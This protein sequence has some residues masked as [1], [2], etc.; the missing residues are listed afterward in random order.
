MVTVNKLAPP[1][2]T[3]DNYTLQQLYGLTHSN[4]TK[5][6]IINTNATELTPP[7]GIT[8]YHEISYNGMK[9]SVVNNVPVL[10]PLKGTA[11]FFVKGDTGY[12]PPI[13]CKAN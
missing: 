5:Y 2:T 8:A 11:I 13:P 1:I 10:V 6:T 7:T 9:N 12:S 4:T 3:L